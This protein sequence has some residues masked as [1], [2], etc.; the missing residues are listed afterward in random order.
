MTEPGRRERNRLEVEAR[1]VEAALALFAAS[2]FD[3]VSIEAITERAG[4]SRRTFFRYFP[5]KEDVVLAR[6]VAHLERFRRAL[7]AR[8]PGQPPFAAVRRACEELADDYD[9]QRARI[10]AERSLFSA[11]PSLLARDLELDRGFEAAIAEALTVGDDP[12][13]RRRARIAAA[14]VVGALRVVLEEWAAR[15]GRVDLPALGRDAL[16]LVAPLA[17]AAPPGASPD[18]APLRRPAAARR[19]STP[20]RPSRRG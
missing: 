9:R 5:S 17:P 14:A 10:L 16:D 19:P 8:S 1:L 15:R 3:A 18:G 7:A 20:R 11:A 6:R 2:G 12:A 4:V 13:V